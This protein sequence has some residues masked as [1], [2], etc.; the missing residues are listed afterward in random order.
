MV[1]VENI[2]GFRFNTDCV[3]YLPRVYDLFL[4]PLDK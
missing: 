4:A 1:E 2:V 3:I